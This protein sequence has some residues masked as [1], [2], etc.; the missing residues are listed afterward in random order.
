[1]LAAAGGCKAGG[2]AVC[3]TSCAIAG[4]A[5]A[6]TA[7]AINNVLVRIAPLRH[8]HLDLMRRLR[9]RHGREIEEGADEEHDDDNQHDQ[10]GHGRAFAERESRCIVL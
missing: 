5:I 4:I 10:S 7:E 6:K 9:L 1:V 8:G 3:A 2:E